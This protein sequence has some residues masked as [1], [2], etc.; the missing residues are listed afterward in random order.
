MNIVKKD[1]KKIRKIIMEVL[2]TRIR[3]VGYYRY[4][5]PDTEN[6]GDW[7][8]DDAI[9][10]HGIRIDNNRLSV[11]KIAHRMAK[12]IYFCYDGDEADAC[13]YDE[14]FDKVKEMYQDQ[15]E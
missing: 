7:R 12:V 8:D 5:V 3:E 11:E 4:V 13:D 14:A 9:V 1:L 10:R 15:F 2:P 6:W